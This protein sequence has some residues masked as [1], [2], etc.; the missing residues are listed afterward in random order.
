MRGLYKYFD[1]AAEGRSINLYTISPIGPAFE[2]LVEATAVF[3]VGILPTPL[4]AELSRSFS[5]AL[6][7]HIY[8]RLMVEMKDAA[9]DSLG[10]YMSTLLELR[11]KK[12]SDVHA[13]NRCYV[14]LGLCVFSNMKPAN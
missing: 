7:R 4:S 13:K 11:H 14:I 2:K 5:L 12:Y 3:T 8:A 6:T 1:S 9:V 10:R